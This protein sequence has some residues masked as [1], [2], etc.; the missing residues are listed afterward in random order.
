M[1]NINFKKSLALKGK[2]HCSIH[3]ATL[4]TKTDFMKFLVQNLISQLF[5]IQLQFSIHFTFSNQ[6]YYFLP[7]LLFLVLILLF[8][9]F[10]LLF[11]AY[12]TFLYQFYFFIPILLFLVQPI[13]WCYFQMKCKGG[14]R[15]L[16]RLSRSY[17]CIF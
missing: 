17:K 12:F 1:L 4:S 5:Q 2:F 3:L 10:I 9:V 8:L 13:V 6:K 15:K 14:E 16:R 11:L 7:I